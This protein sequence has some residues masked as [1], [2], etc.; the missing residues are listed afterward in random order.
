[1]N[2]NLKPELIRSVLTVK[3]TKHL[4]PHYIRITLTGEDVLLFK[5]AKVGSNN[6]IFLPAQGENE[7]HFD[8]SI[9]RT[10][11]HRGINLDKN[12]MAIDFVAHGETGPASAWAI[13]AKSGDPLGVAMK[14]TSS[15]LYPEVD[16]YLLVA[17]ATGIPVIAAILES[18]PASAKGIAFIEVLNKNEEIP[19]TTVADIQIR[20]VHNSSPGEKRP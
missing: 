11:T 6:K 13:N 12:E 4:S 17:D 18:L 10:Y 2:K 5:D 19:L 7:T 8:S 20:W 9:R 15:P 1:M 14:V 16:W 3:H